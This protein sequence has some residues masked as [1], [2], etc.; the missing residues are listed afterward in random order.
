MIVSMADGDAKPEL[1]VLP[2]I[3]IIESGKA[4]EKRGT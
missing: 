4:L 3:L 2:R 1:R